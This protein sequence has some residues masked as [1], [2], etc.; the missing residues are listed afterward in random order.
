MHTILPQEP[1]QYTWKVQTWNWGNRTTRIN[2]VLLAII[3]ILKHNS[4]MCAEFPVWEDDEVLELDS[5]VSCNVSV[6][7]SLNSHSKMFKI[8]CFTIVFKDSLF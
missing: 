4:L 6:L 5:G 1:R 8:V 7:M 2:W 3:C